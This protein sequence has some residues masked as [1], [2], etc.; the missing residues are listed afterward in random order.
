VKA[1]IIINPFSG[2]GRTARKWGE[3][4][5][6]VRSRL[7]GV[8][9]FSTTGPQDA[10]RFATQIATQ[11]EID[12]LIIAGGD[13]SVNEVING[14]FDNKN[15]LINKN[16]KLGILSAGRGCD[17]IRS[18]NIPSDFRK[19]VDVL[20]DPF[21]QNVDVGC[22]LFKDEFGREQRRYFINIACAGLAGIVAKK[23]NSL[24]RSIP[25]QLTYFGSV[26][27]SFFTAKGKIVKI[28]VDEEVVF[29]GLALNV[30][31]ANG[32]Y[33]GAGMCWAPMAKVDDGKFEIIVV[34]PIPKYQILFSGHKMYDGTFVTMPGVHHFQG[35][36]VIVETLD[37]VY[38]EMDGEQP[39]LAPLACT[40]L[41]Q[42]LSF[43]VQ[44]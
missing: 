20:V 9:E 27:S 21:F 5:D 16:L 38:L 30:F 44:S 19:A 25:P 15:E 24:P 43:A 23:F 18:L 39:G 28:F 34:E 14:L 37:D 8:V 11:G 6:E 42:I 4:R 13:G 35:K 32:S 31:I 12:M 26:A 1:A 2:G 10:T 7:G 40:I 41:P 36:A 22:A 33:S 3:I 29:E 17:F